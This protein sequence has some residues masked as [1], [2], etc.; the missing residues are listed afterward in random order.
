MSHARSGV[1]TRSG[2]RSVGSSRP[3]RIEVEGAPISRARTRPLL[4]SASQSSNFS[5]SWLVMRKP[6]GASRLYCP[7][8]QNGPSLATGV[9]RRGCATNPTAF[10]PLD[11]RLKILGRD[12][13][14]SFGGEGRINGDRSRKGRDS[15]ISFKYARETG[16]S[17]K[18]TCAGGIY[19]RG[20]LLVRG[21]WTGQG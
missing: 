5:T 16:E 12:P 15:S 10:S 4:M 19:Q 7:I 13:A 21:V 8:N 3:F 14:A 9:F 17:L 6:R 20:L 2:E 11:E 18:A 1:I